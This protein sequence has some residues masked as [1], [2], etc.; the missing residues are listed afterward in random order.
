M[1]TQDIYTESMSRNAAEEDRLNRQFRV[2]TRWVDMEQIVVLQRLTDA[3]RSV[4]CF[5]P[6]WYPDSQIVL[7]SPMSRLA[8][9]YSSRKC[10]KVIQ[11]RD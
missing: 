11:E 3:V 1:A 5:I 4:G 7:G 10:Q 9:E 2:I 6:P 8:Q